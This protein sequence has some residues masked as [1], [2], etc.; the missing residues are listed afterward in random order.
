MFVARRPTYADRPRRVAFV[1]GHPT[2]RGAADQTG[3]DGDVNMGLAGSWAAGGAPRWG[4]TG[5]AARPPRR[6]LDQPGASTATE[7]TAHGVDAPA[8]DVLAKRP[9]WQAWRWIWE[10]GRHGTCRARRA[11]S[12][13]KVR[14]GGGAQSRS[15]EARAT[16]RP[17]RSSSQS[18]SL[19][20]V[21]GSWSPSCIAG[22]FRRSPARRPSRSASR[23]TGTLRTATTGCLRSGFRRCSE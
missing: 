12:N 1:D 14:G 9:D 20:G 13:I 19:L 5:P 10:R 22:I 6:T 3:H 8:G 18:S 23:R 21:S 15:F 11:G 7:E 17:V 2:H 16:A 4:R